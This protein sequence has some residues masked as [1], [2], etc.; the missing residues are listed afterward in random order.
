[1]GENAPDRPAT[2]AGLN[3]VLMVLVV[4]LAAAGAYIIHLR[5]QL[6]QLAAAPPR[7]AAPLAPPEARPP[8][9][10][11]PAQRPAAAAPAAAPAEDAIAAVLTPAQQQ[12]MVD[13]LKNEAAADRKVWFQVQA[14]NPDTVA[15]QVALQRVFE[16]AGWPTETVRGSYAL[17]S[18]IFMLAGDDQPPAFVDTVSSAFGAAGIDVQYLTG[19]RAFFESRKQQNANWV[20]PE[21]A[22]GQPYILVIGSKPT[23][24]PVAAPE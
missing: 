13:I 8:E 16:Q 17:K 4:A 6:A 2:P 9:A 19:Y 24:K 12:T 22:A 7:Q 21:L 20:G 10:R 3:V 23:P 1:M 18:G 5:G 14:S 11:P 15:V